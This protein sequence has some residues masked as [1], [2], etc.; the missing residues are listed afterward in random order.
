M[1]LL[2]W[3]TCS[4]GSVLKK[5]RKS[6]NKLVTAVPVDETQA[7][8]EHSLFFSFTPF[9]PSLHLHLFFTSLLCPG[10]FQFTTPCSINFL[11]LSTS[12]KGG[13]DIKLGSLFDPSL[14]VGRGK[15]ED[16]SWTQ[17][18]VCSQTSSHQKNE[19]GWHFEICH[20]AK[21]TLTR[22][23]RPCSDIT[24]A[25]SL[26]QLSSAVQCYPSCYSA[27]SYVAVSTC[28]SITMKA[29]LSSRRL[30][31]A[32][33][34]CTVHSAASTP[35]A[36]MW[37][38]NVEWTKCGVDWCLNKKACRMTYVR[39][40]TAKYTETCNHL[41]YVLW[42]VL[43]LPLKFRLVIFFFFFFNVAAVHLHPDAHTHTPVRGVCSPSSCTH[44]QVLH[45]SPSQL[46]IGWMPSEGHDAPVSQPGCP[47]SEQQ[48][49]TDGLWAS[50]HPV[51]PTLYSYIFLHAIKH[52]RG[53][54]SVEQNSWKWN[55]LPSCPHIWSQIWVD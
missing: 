34:L 51:S 36:I 12:S 41:A 18:E 54:C 29:Q 4:P 19:C 16:C 2:I 24:C 20:S 53:W 48:A 15:R 13:I 50:F 8:L 30:H 38:L 1:L 46:L 26:L 42:F 45:C 5:Q 22:L 31:A 40:M 27:I 7:D 43:F 23:Q 47:D 17:T 52:T 14:A 33:A 49:D 9:L 11:F 3:P 39:Q 35:A 37:T 55:S 28:D 32:F 44:A 21:C 25:M 6:K 10:I